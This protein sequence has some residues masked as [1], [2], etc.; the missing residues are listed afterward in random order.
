MIANLSEEVRDVYLQSED[1]AV[2]RNPF[3]A[4]YYGDYSGCPPI[5]LWASG[6][7]VL[8]DDSV[9]LYEKLK[10]A[11]QDCELYLRDGMMHGYPGTP[12]FPEAEEDLKVMKQRMD[13][14]MGGKTGF[15][16][17]LTKLY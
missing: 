2:L 16:N 15:G 9:Y 8:R 3:A 5:F 1:P 4:P 14:V 10:A 17:H 13:E 7:E 11:G 6:S 12:A